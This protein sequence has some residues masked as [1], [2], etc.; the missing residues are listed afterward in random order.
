MQK[1]VQSRVQ[2]GESAPLLLFEAK[3]CPF[4]GEQPTIQSWPGGKPSKRMVACENEACDV[5]PCVTGETRKV[6]I[7][8][9]DRRVP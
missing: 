5:A 9:W 2:S 3:P 1:K 8:R 4:C 6:A 7:E